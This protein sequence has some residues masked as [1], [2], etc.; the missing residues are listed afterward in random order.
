MSYPLCNTNK[1]LQIFEEYA[2]NYKIT[3]NETKS[4]LLYFSYLDKDHSDLL[5]LTMKGKCYTISE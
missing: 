2:L 1:M 3:F 4:Q 5:N